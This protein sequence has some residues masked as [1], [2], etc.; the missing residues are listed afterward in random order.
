MTDATVHDYASVNGLRMYFEVQ[1]VGDPLVLVHGAFSA[2][3]TSFGKLLP[4]LVKTRKVIAVELQ[5]HG[6]TADID[7]PLTDEFL[8]DDIAA[9][10]R[11]LS[12]EQVDVFGWSLGASVATQFAIAHPALVRKLVLASPAYGRD[13]FRPGLLETAETVTPDALDGT[14]WHEEYA[15]IAP[16]P[17]NWPQLVAKVTQHDREWIG[18]PPE[19]IQS[20]RAPTLLIAGDSD[21]VRPEHIVEMFRLLGGGV[22]ADVAGFPRCQLA[23]LP[24]TGHE[25]IPDR[26]EWLASMLQ[27][28]LDS[29]SLGTE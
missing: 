1:S 29:P 13:G 15:R 14:R 19:A 11:E 26:A 5:G 16:H 6:R 21:I 25:R 7:R 17:E 4:L 12:L 24:G 28:F 20:I 10:L 23:V 3:G 2:I 27:T 9:L 22:A 8:A 18:W